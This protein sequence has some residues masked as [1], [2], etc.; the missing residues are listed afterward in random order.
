MEIDLM[1]LLLEGLRY[2]AIVLFYTWWIFVIWLLFV[3]WQNKR[4][5]QF[6]TN[7]K[8]I[9]LQIKVP[10]ENEKTALAAELMFSTLHGIHKPK[11][12]RFF[13]GSIQE[14]LSFEIASFGDKINFYVWTP[15]I[16]R[17]FVEGQVYAQYPTAEIQEVADYVHFIDKKVQD[18]EHVAYTELSLTGNDFLPLKT[19]IDFEVDPLSAIT[20]TLS[21]HS[22]ESKEEI[23]IQILVRPKG[24][25]WN[26][27]GG[28]FIEALKSG[29]TPTS[30]SAGS[31]LKATFSFLGETL[32]SLVSSPEPG[33]GGSAPVR[34]SPI[35]EAK[36]KAAE[37]KIGKLG[38]E[39]KI[40]IMGIN[41]GNEEVGPRLQAVASTF[42][43]FTTNFN[44]FSQG[45]LIYGKTAL[46]VYKNRLFRDAGY[47]LTTD[48]LA[49]IF[50]LPNIS[51]STPAISWTGSKKGEPPEQLP[52]RG[53]VSEKELT[54]FAQ[55][56]FRGENK[57]FG[58]KTDDR[59]RHMYMVG[60]TG[61][62]KSTLMENMIIDDIKEGRGVGV[63]DPHGDLIEKILDFIPPE[64]INDVV[65]LDPSD[66]EFPI[67]FNPLQATNQDQRGL[68]VSGMISIF[69]KLWAFSWGPR[70]E[71]ILR[72]TLFALL[73][74][75]NAT[76]MA[77]PRMLTDNNFRK[78]VKKYITDLEIK[79][80]W[81]QE[82]TLFEQNERLKTEAVSP[83]LNKVGQFLST[84]T[85][86]NVLG[87]PQSDIDIRAIM[88]E[89]KILLVKLSQ[90][91]IGED[92]SALLGNMLITQLQLA[93]MSRVDIPEDQRKDF[94]LYI[95]E[96]QNFATPTFV[97]I[98][99][100]ARKYRLC[101]VLTN[102][103]IAQMLE[104]VRDAVFGNVGTIVSFRVGAADGD[105]LARELEPFTE[106]DVVNLDKYNVYVKLAIDGITS[107]AFSAVTLP[108]PTDVTGNKNKVIAQS[109]ERY[110]SPR[111]KVEERIAKWMKI[112]GEDENTDETD[113][114]NNATNA[115]MGKVTEKQNYVIKKHPENA[116][117]KKVIDEYREF[118]EEKTSGESKNNEKTIAE[119]LAKEEL[120]HVIRKS[121][122][123]G[124]E[125]RENKKVATE[126]QE[127]ELQ[128]KYVNESSKLRVE[129]G[130]NNSEKNHENNHV[131]MKAHEI[132]ENAVGEIKSEIDK[133]KELATAKLNMMMKN[134]A[135]SADSGRADYTDYK[136]SGSSE[137]GTNLSAGEAGSGENEKANKGVSQDIKLNHGTVN[138][139]NK[140]PN[141]EKKNS[142]ELNPGDEIRL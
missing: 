29:S 58:I 4:K 53:V 25:D 100:E 1:S 101:L 74:Y 133:E 84:S 37:V 54:P 120:D 8:T 50:H 109:R 121:R 71:H 33:G 129:N 97:K 87:Q 130:E 95:D 88:D 111:N 105:F 78:K 99:S 106:T 96:F 18:G 104:E 77:V 114:I 63:V 64:R 136:K 139:L 119:K 62:G 48:E 98:L 115:T 27:R 56:N 9:L 141:E 81:T 135:D 57:V 102:Q 86:R 80:F 68:V 91:A 46:A 7:Q 103:Y 35:D 43:Q 47:V 72:N 138:L 22:A 13:E 128:N 45:G 66:R 20:S 127:K 113:S 24:E 134:N 21:K 123:L 36:A 39:T 140:K 110:A 131:R 117:Q 41:P 17:D 125:S 142:G 3:S 26:H 79:R 6:V 44:G 61:T 5:R 118:M 32:S 75:P 52:V 108:P 51:V 16:Y 11:K 55:T 19:F 15:E 67:S 132:L 124:V 65:I 40:R 30:F 70:L 49:S 69:Q 107:P 94:Y 93:A 10:K 14:H 82:F 126:S 42:K 60:K 76:L 85:V 59:R 31:A 92:N 2:I 112:E 90:G 89:G 28:S 34:I 38:F 83:I 137:L 116:L 73:E 23:W 122:E 12:K